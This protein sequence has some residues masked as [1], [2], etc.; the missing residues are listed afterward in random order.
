MN[1]TH[2]AEDLKRKFCDDQQQHHKLAVKNQEAPDE[3][4]AETRFMRYV[5]GK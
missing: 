2:V 4:D 5:E 1:S 3:D